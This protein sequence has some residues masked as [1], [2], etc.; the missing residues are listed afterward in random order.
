MNSSKRAHPVVAL[1]ACSFAVGK[2]AGEI[3]LFPAGAFRAN[4]GRPEALA[5]WV[6]NAAVAQKLIAQFAARRNPMV[7]DYE[8]QTYFSADNGQPALAAGWIDALRWVEPGDGVAGGLFATVRW[9]ERAAAYIAADEYKYISPVFTYHPKT[10]GVVSLINAA[11]TNNP[12]IDDMQAVQARMAAIFLTQ[13][14]AI[15][16]VDELLERLHYLFN[17]PALATAEDVLT[18]MDKA[19][20]LI[21]ADAVEDA[22][23]KATASGVLGLLAQHKAALVLARAAQPNPAEYV[24]ITTFDAIK[25]ELAML[26]AVQRGDEIEAAL[27][28]A[29][30]A[31]R[32]QPHELDWLRSVGKQDLV[33]LKQRLAVAPVMAA[34]VATQTGGR[35]LAGEGLPTLADHELAMCKSMGISPADFAKTRAAQNA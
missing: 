2:A 17:L 24:P 7:L 29:L 27:Q 15:M 20:A 22:A 23:V 28:V 25:A 12:A 16:D 9:T 32:A 18:E 4:D 34:T 3:Q 13:E 1:N 31:G 19:I 5:A 8:H 10:G 30:S 33:L 14:T 35:S 26:K 6:M 11:L 21:K